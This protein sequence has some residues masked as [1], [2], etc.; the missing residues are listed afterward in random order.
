[1]NKKKA[2]PHGT[3]SKDT[4]VTMHNHTFITHSQVIVRDLR[5]NGRQGKSSQEFRDQYQIIDVPKAVSRLNTKGY[6]IHS[7]K[8]DEVDANGILRKGIVRY[9]L[10]SEPKR[11]EEAA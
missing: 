10:I 3:A 7:V 5:E 4:Q 1:M 8:V 11:K 9:W 6:H 2:T